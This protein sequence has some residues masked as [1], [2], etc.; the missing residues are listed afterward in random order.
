[1]DSQ[2]PPPHE[3][4]RFDD[5]KPEEAS[6]RYARYFMQ[7]GVLTLFFGALATIAGALDFNSLMWVFGSAGAVALICVFVFIFKI[8]Q[9]IHREVSDEPSDGDPSEA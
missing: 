4:R 5:P 7:S 6:E 9:A 8:D 1:M 3:N 2:P